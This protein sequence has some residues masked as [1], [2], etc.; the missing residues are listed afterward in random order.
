[1]YYLAGLLLVVAWLLYFLRF[2]DPAIALLFYA[3]WVVLAAG[4]VLIFL[5]LLVLRARGRPEEGKDI[6]HTT[7]LITGGIYAVARHPLYLGWLLL[8]VAV[9]LFSQHWLVLILGIAGIA[10]M[11]Q[12]SR[13]EDRRLVERFGV[14][15]KEYMAAV[16]ALNLLAGTWRL[17]RR[18]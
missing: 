3:G 16:P 15:Y 6:T 7:T 18:R 13:Q 4:L 12:I 14:A 10:C 17:L 9:M 5:P 1:M 11:V 8:Y 2:H